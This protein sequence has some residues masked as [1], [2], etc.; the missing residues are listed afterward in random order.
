MNAKTPARP[1]M[2]LLWGAAA[3]LSLIIAMM[4]GNAISGRFTETP[5]PEAISAPA[6]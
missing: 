1:T 3:V 4:I 6:S 2:Y 5:P